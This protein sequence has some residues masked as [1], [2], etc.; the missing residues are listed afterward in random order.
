MVMN[1]EF[2]GLTPAE[3]LS[4][5]SGYKYS[6]QVLISTWDKGDSNPI[7]TKS[8]FRVEEGIFLYFERNISDKKYVVSVLYPSSRYPQVRILIDK[9]KKSKKE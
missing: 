5:E 6:P 7:H 4:D 1:G 2:H 9:W 3:L 8:I